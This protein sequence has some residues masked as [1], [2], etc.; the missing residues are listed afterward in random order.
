MLVVIVEERTVQLDLVVQ[1]AGLETG[2]DGVQPFGRHEVDLRRIGIGE[3]V[4]G[5][6]A[7]TAA[8]AQVRADTLCPFIVENGPAGEVT[9]L[10]ARIDVGVDRKQYR[11]RHVLHEV[12]ERVQELDLVVAVTR[13]D[14][15][16]ELGRQAV[17]AFAIDRL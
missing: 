4:V 5:A 11:P 9:L 15:N 1:Q 14:G 12:G 6:R 10:A 16:I 2:L 3:T 13:A 17:R 8:E 7:V